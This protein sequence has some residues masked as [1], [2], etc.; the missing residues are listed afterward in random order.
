MEFTISLVVGIVYTTNRM[1]DHIC[2]MH[3]ES[4]T[5][6]LASTSILS[7]PRS[8]FILEELDYNN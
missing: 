4:V 3:V 5:V 7:L 2:K 8:K 6:R 1:F